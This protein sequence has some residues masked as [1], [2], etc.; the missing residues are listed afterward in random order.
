MGHVLPCRG[1][2][3][4]GDT[5]D[6]A[7][8]DYHQYKED[9]GLMKDLGLKAARFSIAWSRIFPNGTG[10]PNQAGVDHYSEVVDTML[11]RGIQ[12]Y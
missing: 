6:I 12:P 5:G 11:E 8:D 10:Q 2:T 1:Q 4:N 3:H 7:D 9:I